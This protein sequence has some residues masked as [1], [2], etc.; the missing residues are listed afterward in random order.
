MAL[1]NKGL[2]ENGVKTFFEIASGF[3]TS[4]REILVRGAPGRGA[5]LATL[6]EVYFHYP[7]VCS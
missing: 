3:S 4:L 7:D 1:F 5:I 6:D 2:N